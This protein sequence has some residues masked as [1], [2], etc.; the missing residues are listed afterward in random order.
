MDF[1]PEILWE[2]PALLVINKPAGLRTLPDG[3]DPALPYVRQ[4]LE[5]AYGRLWMVHRLDKETS[6]VLLLARSA[7]AHRSL[8]TQ[9]ERRQLNK[10]YHALAGASP[11]WDEK[12]VSM[13]LRIN[14]DRRHRTVVDHRKGKPAITHLRVLVRFP[15]AALIE[16][17]PETGRTHQ[18]R[19]HL[20]AIG[21]PLL[22]DALYGGVVPPRLNLDTLL[23]HAWVLEITHPASGEPLRFE[24]PYPEAFRKVLSQLRRSLVK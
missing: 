10:F 14:G 17:R 16:A 2:D 15:Q 19:A 13:P 7:D 11:E 9:F 18:I 1:T 8:N 20:A 23:L 12:T 21:L 6:G 3:Y 24:A 5:P 22:A 4:L